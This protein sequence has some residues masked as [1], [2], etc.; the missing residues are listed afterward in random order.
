MPQIFLNFLFYLA[1]RGQC[2]SKKNDVFNGFECKTEEVIFVKVTHS[3]KFNEVTWRIHQLPHHSM[4][5][6]LRICRWQRFRV[7]CYWSDSVWPVARQQ[8][9]PHSLLF[10]A[11][12]FLLFYR[13]LSQRVNCQS[14]WVCLS[15]AR[16]QYGL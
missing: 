12:V 13:P 1:I 15:S 7:S 8:Q 10:F 2:L 4:K 11:C 6:K 14:M 5:R 9:P 3:K 16:D